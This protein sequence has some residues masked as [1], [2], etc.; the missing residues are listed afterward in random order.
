MDKKLWIYA[1]Y[2]KYSKE[3]EYQLSNYERSDSSGD[4]LLE[5]QTVTFETPEEKETRVKLA[6]SLRLKLVH[7]KAYHYKEQIEEQEA[8]NEL[9]SLEYKPEIKEKGRR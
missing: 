8:I 1:H 4:V 5:E 7:L 3:I 2:N 6:A 9:L